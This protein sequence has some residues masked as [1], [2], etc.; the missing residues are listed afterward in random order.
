MQGIAYGLNVVIDILFN[1]VQLVIIGSIIIS[2]LNAPLNNPIVQMIHT[3]TEPLY[4]L[5][6]PISNKINL[7]LDFSPMIILLILIFIH[8]VS[9][10]YL[11]RLAAG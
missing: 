1:M 11:G 9:T 7:P 3:L 5:V 6:R 2:W 10:F 4:R 8:K